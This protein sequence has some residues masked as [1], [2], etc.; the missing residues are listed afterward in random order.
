MLRLAIIL[1]IILLPVQLMAASI[2]PSF[3]FSTIRT[4]HFIIH[5]HQGLEETAI[6]SSEIAEEAHHM[7]TPLFNWTPEEKTHIILL[8]N[9]DLAN[10]LATVLPYNVIYI[11]T[12]PP[13][14]DMTI[15]EY[16]DWLKLVIYHEYSH[17]LTM[18][19]VRGYSKTMRRIFGK[20]LPGYD[21]LSF[22]GFLLT[23]PPNVFMPYWWLEGMSVWAETEFSS[24]GRGKSSFYEMI[25][26][27][28]VAENNLLTI[29]RI[30][31]DIPFW[32]DGHVP[33]IYGLA[34][35]K[36][37]VAKYGAEM[38][39]KLNMLH[40]GRLP[41]F[42]TR[43]SKDL[44]GKNYVELYREM[45][46][47]LKIEEEKKIEILKTIPF[48]QFNTLS[49]SG[50]RLTNP[51]FSPSAQF[52]ATTI[53]DPHEHEGIVIVESTK[54]WKKNIIRRLSSDRNIT[55]SPD[56]K[57]IYFTQAE[58]IKGY[59]LYQDIYYYNIEE[60]KVVQ[61]TKGLRVKDPDI[62]PD[63]KTF[64][65][66]K[67]DTDTQSLSLFDLETHNLKNLIEYK[68]VRLSGP[69]WSPDGRFITFSL[70]DNEGKTSLWIYDIEGE[71][72]IKLI[73]DNFNN[74]YPT[75]SPDGRFI[76]F[77][78]DKTGVYNLFAYSLEEKE[79]HMSHSDTN[80]NEK[81]PPSPP[82]SK[83]GKGGFSGEIYQITH[84]MG[85]AFQP[86]ASHDG[87]HILFSSYNSTG[88]K[89]AMMEYNPDTWSKI[90]SPSI[91][92]YWQSLKDEN[93][94]MDN[95]T[96]E[97]E[98]YTPKST[99]RRYSAFS[100]LIPRF[101]L[102]TLY[103]DD[104][105]P[106]FGAFTAG[107]DVL[108]YH[109]FTANAGYGTGGE[110]YYDLLYIYDRFYPT[111]YLS[112][113]SM[114]ALYSDFFDG[115][116]YYE[117]ETG[118]SLAM[119]FPL[120]RVESEYRL[121][122]GYQLKKQE[123]LSD[124]ETPVFEGRRDNIFVG[125]EFNNTLQYPYS[126]SKEEGRIISVYFRDY[127]KDRN[128]DIDS[129]EYIG[130]YEEYIGLENHNVVFLKFKGAISEGDTISQQAFQLGGIYGNTTEY[131]LR[132]YSS[133][134]LTGR[135]IITETI[136]YRLPIKYI[137]RGVG[138]KPFFWDRI[139][140]AAFTDAGT[141]WGLGKDFK[142]EDIKVGVGGEARL[143]MVLGYKLHIT[144]AIGIAHGISEGGEDIVYFTI[145]VGL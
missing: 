43:P 136:E 95:N 128:S 113:Y 49:I 114:P 105:G 124:P 144:P 135:Y 61:I 130:S 107:Q 111:F 82:F 90:I 108:G 10:G 1:L 143:D 20:T 42:I 122:M 27:M 94:N 125:I 44:T 88:Y 110:A 96:N 29:D 2:D 21:P 30:N 38:L 86:D 15:G 78:S 57:G 85:G 53:R 9:T 69:R 67:I 73:E 92:P 48:T 79:T 28:A 142:W 131:P 116:D 64:A 60:D 59:N 18:D 97:S 33:Y 77:T 62:S 23:A 115:E 123:S 58:L 138:T 127:S 109:T 52:I 140:V 117:R 51:R 24:M 98:S 83:G 103:F 36:Y 81:N 121:I 3:K 46:E 5:Y 63:G 68:G 145:Y 56:E 13:M 93:K 70:R 75:Y 66:I 100:T 102:P 65:L 40:A 91:E 16:E 87:K 34:L 22:F 25:F 104:D 17:I 101:W 47:D 6:K 50:E 55:W 4:D 41:F 84:I 129:R 141:V 37:I 45:L 89:I 80:D 137:L 19:P 74:C 132:G 133:R 99:P 7:L 14:V 139:H 26:R 126:I 120:R 12:V 32:P 76:I 8:D 71:T 31:G 134:F 35:K 112:G 11:F 119:S 39:G 118:I 106:V 72:S 54:P